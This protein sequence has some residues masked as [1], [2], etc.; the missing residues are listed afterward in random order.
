[1]LS[2]FILKEFGRLG[3]SVENHGSRNAPLFAVEMT[4]NDQAHRAFV[5]YC[6]PDGQEDIKSQD[7]PLLFV[8]AAHPAHTGVTPQGVENWF[9]I[10]E[11]SSIL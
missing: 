8:V 11:A 5:D 4:Y 2:S 10:L 1:M 3:A 7:N 6:I 9:I